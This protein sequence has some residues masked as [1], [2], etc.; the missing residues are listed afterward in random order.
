LTGHE[1]DGAISLRVMFRKYGGVEGVGSL[2]I[3]GFV[4]VMGIVEGV[5]DD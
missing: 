2:A 3:T 4:Q 1:E 5:V